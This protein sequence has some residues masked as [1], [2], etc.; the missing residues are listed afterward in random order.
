[1]PIMVLR[2]VKEIS[3]KR[4]L[5]LLFIVLFMPTL[6]QASG[7]SG[8]YGTWRSHPGLSGGYLYID[9]APCENAGNKV[10]GK[11]VQAFDGR[12]KVISDYIFLGKLAIRDM[13]PIKNNFWSKGA[14]WSPEEEKSYRGGIRLLEKTGNLKVTGCIGFLC[15]HYFWK[16]IN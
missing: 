3:M 9:L 16:K 6:L 4:V 13:Q 1:M 15:Q 10:C 2:L 7:A 5:L 8:V 14:L 11:I 12:G